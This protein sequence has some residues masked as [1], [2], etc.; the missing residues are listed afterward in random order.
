V[1]FASLGCSDAPA[2]LLI[3]IAAAAT[4]AAT[5]EGTAQRRRRE[6]AMRVMAT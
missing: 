1:I 3:E 6:V 2:P 5:M 4:P